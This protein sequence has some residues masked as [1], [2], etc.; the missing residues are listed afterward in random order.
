M[1]IG[2]AANLRWGGRFANRP[3]SWA[4]GIALQLGPR[5]RPTASPPEPPNQR[6][7]LQLPRVFVFHLTLAGI[8]LFIKRCP[9]ARRLSRKG[10]LVQIGDGPAAVIGDDGCLNATGLWPGRRGRSVDPRVRRP[11]RTKQGSAAWTMPAPKTI[12]HPSK[13]GHPG[14]NISIRDFCF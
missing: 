1:E 9:G 4:P 11:A 14:S 10:N 8:H 6:V 7:Y 12:T 3:Y 5:D 2:A 13:K